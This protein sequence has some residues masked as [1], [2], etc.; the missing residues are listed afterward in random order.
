MDGETALLWYLVGP[1][2][3]DYYGAQNWRNE[4]KKHLS[5]ID[6]YDANAHVPV[7][8][9]F[10]NPFEYFADLR[11]RHCICQLRGE[12]PSLLALNY[13]SV[14]RAFGLLCYEPYPVRVS[15]WGTIREVVRAHDQGKPIV[16]WTEVPR[17]ERSFAAIAMSTVICPTLKRAIGVCR[18][19]EKNS[20]LFLRRQP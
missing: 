18:G 1:M 12:F 11:R 19:I 13:Q 16:L 5:C 2:A 3:Q 20:D 4:A 17:E 14:D 7:P 6:P 15:S 8:E 10:A 9:P